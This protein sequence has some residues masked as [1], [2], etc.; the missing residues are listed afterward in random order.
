MCVQRCALIDN[1]G[2]Q[3]CGSKLLVD[4][5]STPSVHD[6]ASSSKLQPDLPHLLVGFDGPKQ[7]GPHAS[8]V[9]N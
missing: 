1:A 9:K 8:D 2:T 4:K 5:W 7:S 6:H 3:A